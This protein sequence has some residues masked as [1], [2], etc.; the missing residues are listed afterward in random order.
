VGRDPRL[1]GALFGSAKDFD[2]RFKQEYPSYQTVPYQ[3]AQAAAAVVVWKDALERAGSFDTNR[4]REALAATD[5]ETFYGPIRFA[6]EGN[7]TA[8]PMVL[9]QIQDGQYVVVAPTK[10][11]SHPVVFP[12]QA[13]H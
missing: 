3:A 7:N 6:P 11:A 10:W 13:K 8:K 12:R 9:R 2:A 5:L 1:K 4:L